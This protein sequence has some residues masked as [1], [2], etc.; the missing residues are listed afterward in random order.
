MHEIKI[1]IDRE[2]KKHIDRVMKA[3]ETISAQY[4]DKQVDID[5]ISADFNKLL[6]LDDSVESSNL[7]TSTPKSQPLIGLIFAPKLHSKIIGQYSLHFQSDKI[8]FLS[9]K[10]CD[11]KLATNELMRLELKTLVIIYK[12]P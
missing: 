3:K 2:A 7:G 10:S 11:Y 1:R 8:A 5:N 12:I 4:A 6:G 9:F